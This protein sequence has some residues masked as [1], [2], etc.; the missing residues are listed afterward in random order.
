M[1]TPTR[2]EAPT[3]DPNSVEKAQQA[4][5]SGVVKELHYGGPPPQPDFG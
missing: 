5:D 1:P 4:L 2:V 3:P